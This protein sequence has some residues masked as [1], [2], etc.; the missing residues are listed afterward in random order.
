MKDTKIYHR[1]IRLLFRLFLGMGMTVILLLNF[2]SV[3]AVALEG[4]EVQIKSAMIVNFIRF[5]KWPAADSHQDGERIIVGVM[6]ADRILEVLK[7]QEGKLIDGKPLTVQRFDELKDVRQCHVLSVGGGWS[8]TNNEVLD[9]VAGSSILT[10]GDAEEF[11]REGGMIRL[12]QEKNNIRLEIN[13]TA[14]C[15]ANLQVSAKLLE[16]ATVITQ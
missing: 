8:R 10:I 16:I 14:A 9:A 7:T 1:N 2:C 15:R 11:C 5:V 4:L 6:G 13:N 3:S 12:F